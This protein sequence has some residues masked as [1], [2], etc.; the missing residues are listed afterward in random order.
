[1]EN[2]KLQVPFVE[3]SGVKS[4]SITS[5]QIPLARRLLVSNHTCCADKVIALVMLPILCPLALYSLSYYGVPNPAFPF[6]D[7][8]SSVLNS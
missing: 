8:S 7:K 2:Y 5:F 6:S 3:H 4:V 1:M